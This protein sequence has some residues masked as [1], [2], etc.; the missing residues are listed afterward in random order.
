[1]AR[2]W[3]PDG[4]AEYG[5]ASMG[6]AKARARRRAKRG[7][8]GARRGAKRGSEAVERGPGGVAKGGEERPV[9]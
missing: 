4:A 2:S 3:G 5:G 1:M 6:T 9:G 7:S 8:E